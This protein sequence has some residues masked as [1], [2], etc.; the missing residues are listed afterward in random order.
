MH[1]CTL[2]GGSVWLVIRKKTHQAFLVA[3][4]SKASKHGQNHPRI[5]GAATEKSNKFLTFEDLEPAKFFSFCLN[6]ADGRSVLKSITFFC[7]FVTYQSSYL[8]MIIVPKLTLI[9]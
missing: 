4:F 6:D 2:A 1:A 8:N 9:R 3:S 5:L 7:L